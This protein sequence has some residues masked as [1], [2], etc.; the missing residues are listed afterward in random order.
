[1]G[2]ILKSNLL[3]IVGI[4]LLASMET[5]LAQGFPQC[6]VNP[7][8]AAC[9]SGNMAACYQAEAW[10]CSCYLQADRRPQTPVVRQEHYQW[11]QCVNQAQA[12][13]N[14]LR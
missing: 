14:S 2:N 13:V 1:M 6:Q 4:V 11:Q 3:P 8:R 12:A 7:Y 5:G 9:T 10:V